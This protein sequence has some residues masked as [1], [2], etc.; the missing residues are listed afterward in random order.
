[1]RPVYLTWNKRKH[2]FLQVLLTGG[3]PA[4]SSW[5]KGLV[6]VFRSLPLFSSSLPFDSEDQRTQCRPAVRTHPA[7][8]TKPRASTGAKGFE[9]WHSLRLLA[10]P[11]LFRRLS[12]RLM[13]CT[14]AGFWLVNREGV[15]LWENSVWGFAVPR[16]SERLSFAVVSRKRHLSVELYKMSYLKRIQ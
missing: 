2:G 6:W 7:V 11:F 4:R 14:G 5:Q 13:A 12:T 16:L 10:G 1:M 3:I 15:P 8:S 9:A